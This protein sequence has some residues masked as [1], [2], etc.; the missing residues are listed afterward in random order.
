MTHVHHARHERPPTVG[1]L[2]APPPPTEDAARTRHAAKYA[3]AE[4][5]A[6]DE[7]YHETTSSRMSKFVKV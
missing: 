1:A 6:E 3:D 5:V 2:S 4:P 7:E